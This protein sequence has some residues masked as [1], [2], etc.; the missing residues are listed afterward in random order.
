[1]TISIKRTFAV[2]AFGTLLL[3]GFARAEGITDPKLI[4][5]VLHGREVFGS[6]QT[7]Q[8]DASTRD[9][10][11]PYS[12]PQTPPKRYMYVCV[13]NEVAAGNPPFEVDFYEVRSHPDQDNSL[14]RLTG[15][16]MC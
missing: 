10:D 12:G 5:K 16:G 3:S 15:K 14:V 6:E 7:F 13:K 9:I 4:E 1:M 11:V 2:T 8:L